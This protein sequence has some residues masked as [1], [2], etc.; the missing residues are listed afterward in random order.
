[1]FYDKEKIL[2][3]M[4][5]Y[6][7]QQCEGLT[8]VLE[9]CRA[10]IKVIAATISVEGQPVPMSLRKEASDLLKAIEQYKQ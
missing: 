8:R 6:V 3:S 9:D 5:E 1:M 4:D 10:F 7:S 2:E